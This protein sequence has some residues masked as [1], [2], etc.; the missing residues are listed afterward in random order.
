MKCPRTVLLPLLIGIGLQPA[1]AAGESEVRRWL[2][3]MIN[4]VHSLTYEGTFVLLHDNHLESM[5]LIHAVS[6]DGTKTERLVSLNGHAREVVRDS[7]SVTCI[8]P[9]SRSVSV[10][11]RLRGGGFG[12]VFSMDLEALYEFYHFQL[13]QRARIAERE[14]QVVAI[15]P[16]DGFRYGYRI[17]LDT[18]SFLP[19]KTDMLNA[20]GKVIS[21]IMF[22]NLRV[23]ETLQEIDISNMEGTAGYRWRNRGR[24]QPVTESSNPDWHFEALPAGFAL[25][26][27]TRRANGEGG[28]TDHFVFSD[29][30]ASLSVYI[31]QEDRDSGL[32]GASQMGAI[33]AFGRELDG[34]Q[35]T[36]VG[37]VPAQ[38]VRKVAQAVRPGQG[39]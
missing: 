8:A 32:L 33:N 17:Y 29:G 2:E 14:A 3:Q 1:V 31:E 37:Q 39:G 35:V 18:N 19:L 16:K 34:F 12:A 28:R 24:I 22:T 5:K 7:A 6:E 10:G 9:G 23:A 11:S 15:L 4:S 21:Q 13:L 36:V 20:D 26:L 30:L 25:T 27:Q 38:T